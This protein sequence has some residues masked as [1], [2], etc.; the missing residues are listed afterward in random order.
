M[1]E[2][3]SSSKFNFHCTYRNEQFPNTTECRRH[4]KH[5]AD[6]MNLLN[7]IILGCYIQRKHKTSFYQCSSA[8]EGKRGSYKSLPSHWNQPNA[9]P[10]LLLW[11]ISLWFS[12]RCLG[13]EFQSLKL[14]SQMTASTCD[15]RL[16]SLPSQ[17]R[18]KMTHWRVSQLSLM[19]SL[20]IEPPAPSTN[21]HC[22]KATSSMG[23]HKQAK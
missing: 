7:Q 10:G 5:H 22:P 18:W 8:K 6:E 2:C 11:K 15:Y 4:V 16:Q 9:L 17:G 23:T 14:S 19:M 20:F 1:L 12:H 3:K 13:Q 21:P